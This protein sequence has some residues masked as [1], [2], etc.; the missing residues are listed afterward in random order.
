M[1]EPQRRISLY[2]RS[3]TAEVTGEGLMLTVAW[4][5][6]AEL[7]EGQRAPTPPDVIAEVSSSRAEEPVGGP[8]P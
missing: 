5:L 8:H 4:G 6:D 2:A 7:A 3:G 1:L